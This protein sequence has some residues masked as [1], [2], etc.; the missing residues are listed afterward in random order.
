VFISLR[1]SR[2]SGNPDFGR[3]SFKP[4]FLEASPFFFVPR[5]WMALYQMYFLYN[6][7]W[8]P[9]KMLFPENAKS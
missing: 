3:S 6:I 7:L 2:E 5:L 1:H 9:G 4:N 8:K